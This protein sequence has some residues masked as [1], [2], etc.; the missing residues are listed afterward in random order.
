MML[1]LNMDIL[2]ETKIFAVFWVYGR[3]SEEGPKIKIGVNCIT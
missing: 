2:P 3:L 1:I